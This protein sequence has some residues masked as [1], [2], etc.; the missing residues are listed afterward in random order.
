[1]L[2]RILESN[3]WLLEG[4]AA[5]QASSGTKTAIPLCHMPTKITEL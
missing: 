5:G 3:D 1:V 4:A 2:I